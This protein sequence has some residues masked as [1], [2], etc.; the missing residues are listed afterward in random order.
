MFRVL[1]RAP[2][3][4]D[5]AIAVTLLSKVGVASE[6]CDSL[7]RITE[8][9]ALDA[10]AVLMTEEALEDES[11]ARALL[12][13]V[14]NQPP[15]SDLPFIVLAAPR[16][17]IA[18]GARLPSFFQEIGN[19]VLL[20]RPFGA[21]ALTSAVS[22]ALRAR[23]KQ[24]EL[25]SY[26]QDRERLT[27][28]L[29]NTNVALTTRVTESSRERDRIWTTSQDLLVVADSTGVFRE[30][31][32]A[33]TRT[34]GWRPEDL[35]GR[36]FTDFLD[37]EDQSYDVQALTQPLGLG[38]DGFRNRFR[39]K[40]GS[41]RWVAWRTV[42]ESDRI[43]AT[44]RD[45]TEEIN[46]KLALDQAEEALRQSQKMEAIGQ[47]TG[48]VAHD[49]NNLL[50][51]IRSSIDLLRSPSLTDARKE[52]Y[53]EAI[54]ETTTRA[55]KLTSQLLA[56][57]RRQAL[58]PEVF[59]VGDG[60]RSIGDMVLTLTGSRVRLTTDLASEAQF[61]CADRSQFDTAMI[62]LAV[63]ARDAMDGEGILTVT[64]RPSK[65]IPSARSHPALKGD[66][67]AISVADTGTGIT[68]DNLEKIFEP[69]FTTKGV[70]KG[71]G[72]GLSQVFG[73]AKQ[74]GGDIGVV[75]KPGVGTT[76]TLYLPRSLSKPASSSPSSAETILSD[77][78]RTCVLVVE[79]NKEV[80][81]FATQTLSELGYCP[82][83]ATDA[84]AAL[85]ELGE[86]AD[87]FDVVFSDVIMPGMNGVD[88]AKKIR[89][90][91]ADL[92]V[93]LTSGY[94]H[95]LAEGGTHGFELLHKPYSIDQLSRAL[96][97]AAHWRRFRRSVGT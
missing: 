71:T 72:L 54:S 61:V 21:T 24:Y 6:I 86:N 16:S 36:R 60:V 89:G 17:D 91:F 66:F 20:E 62:N 50:T 65:S 2:R 69:F 41:H 32:P 30:V 59:D 25:R 80:G 73:F 48:G 11:G 95:I 46:Q 13:W 49:F 93:V 82:V 63:N 8:A 9:A 75:S 94:S 81:L 78:H 51:I 64:V 43:Y 28:N 23:R 1:I 76:F 37:I 88:L 7:T 45:V 47:L 84:A 15:W 34:L 29:K 56:F 57:S 52:K 39:H 19:L 68:P 85:A 79:D 10:G 31:N 83:L 92:P 40:D 74:S 35:I 18:L 4:R 55:A 97:K 27:D 53:M 70:G 87:R 3:G 42:V 38:F 12:H 90:R 26:L 22:V 77:G 44:G 5:A 14:S 33:W 67:V 58:N 96:A